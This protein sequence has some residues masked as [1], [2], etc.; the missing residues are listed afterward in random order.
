MMNTVAGLLSPALLAALACATLGVGAVMFVLSRRGNEGAI[1]L[2]M[3]LSWAEPAELRLVLYFLLGAMFGVAALVLRIVLGLLTPTG[4]GAWALLFLVAAGFVMNLAFIYAAAGC[5]LQAALGTRGRPPFW[6]SRLLSPLDGVIMDIGDIVAGV[7]FQPAPVRDQRRTRRG[8]RYEDDFDYYDEPCERP[9]RAVRYERMERPRVAR[10]PYYEGPE[11]YDPEF[12][13]PSAHKTPGRLR[14]E[15]DAGLSP[16]PS[17]RRRASPE[18]A[19]VLDDDTPAG[20][21]RRERPAAATPDPA[22]EYY[23]GDEQVSPRISSG[24]THV[25]RPEGSVPPV[26]RPAFEVDDEEYEPSLDDEPS[27]RAL[28]RGHRGEVRDL[29]RE[30]LE[31]ALE[32][33]EEALTPGQLTRLREMRSLVQTIKQY[34]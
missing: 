30:R 10:R 8:R 19:V 21:T 15:S 3:P 25:T 17:S 26:R 32:E 13:T 24:R 27:I 5:L 14:T 29:P 1:D 23:A 6:F 7:L 22:R 34:V 33:Y 20:R 31:L 11:P 4:L 16:E 18:P 12:D 28:R 9:R 2:T